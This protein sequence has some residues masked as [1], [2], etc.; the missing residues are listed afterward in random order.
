MDE[1]D[2]ALPAS[3][4][5]RT[6]RKMYTTLHT[7]VQPGLSHVV[8]EVFSKELITPYVKSVAENLS[9]TEHSRVSSVLDAL[10]SRIKNKPETFDIFA[11]V[12]DSIESLSYLAKGMR[13]LWT[14]LAKEES[15]RIEEIQKQVGSRIIASL[16]K[17]LNIPHPNLCCMTYEQVVH[18]F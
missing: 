12:L 2:G 18:M 8:T 16:K 17:Q 5:Y 15:D 10:L 4:K 1:H 9:I 14:Q 11:D 7:G 13:E 3:V 6:F